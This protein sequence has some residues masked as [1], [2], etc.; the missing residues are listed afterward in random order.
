MSTSLGD[1][2]GRDDSAESLPPNEGASNWQGVFDAAREGLRSFLISKLPQP[3][4]ADDCLQAVSVAMLQN[5]T[6]IPP[7]AR[8]AWLFRVAANQAALWWRKKATT[9]RLLEKQATDVASVLEETNPNRLETEETLE[10]IRNA[11]SSLPETTQ[12]IVKMRIHDGKTFQN[13]S[14]QLNLPLGTVLTRMRRAMEHLR[15]LFED[16]Q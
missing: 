2:D 11:I 4:D 7:A 14:D 15:R 3:A 13:I 6:E 8:R 5:T 9:D 12:I 10:Q 16:D 1:H